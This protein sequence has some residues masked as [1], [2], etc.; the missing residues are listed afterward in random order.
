MK[1]RRFNRAKR[2]YRKYLN[3]KGLEEHDIDTII[4]KIDTTFRLTKEDPFKLSAEE[5]INIFVRI[6]QMPSY[7]K[8]K[9]T[10]D[11]LYGEDLILKSR[12]LGFEVVSNSTVEKYWG[13]VNNFFD[14]SVS[15]GFLD[16]NCFSNLK[17]KANKVKASKQRDSYTECQLDMLLKKSISNWSEISDLGWILIIAIELGMRQNEI[18]QLHKFDVIEVDGVHCIFVND[19]LPTQSVKNEY[20]VRYL[21]ITK[22]MIRLGFLI[23]VECKNDMLFESVTYCKKNKYSRKVSEHYSSINRLLFD[24]NKLTFHSVRH[25]FVDKLKRNDLPEDVVAEINGRKHDKETF[26]RYGKDR[27]L[28]YKLN[29]LN[30]YGSPSVSRHARKVWFLRNVGNVRNSFKFLF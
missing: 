30:K 7:M 13:A 14:W 3:E 2:F 18:S 23:F 8:Q 22:S 20:S 28:K 24:N 21:P 11:G 19:R 25:Y 1:R 4:N 17:T 15:L 10:L 29:I 16:R 26:G 12:S 9:K 6:Y 27:P 5:S